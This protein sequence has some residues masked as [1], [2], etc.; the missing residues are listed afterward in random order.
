MCAQYVMLHSMT[1]MSCKST[2]A[3]NIGEGER[4]GE[5]THAFLIVF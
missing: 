5:Y 3:K 2:L 1:K 4:R